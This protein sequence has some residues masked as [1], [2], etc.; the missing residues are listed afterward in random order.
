MARPGPRPWAAVPPPDA[1]RVGREAGQR[2][3][4]R[5]VRCRVEGRAGDVPSQRDR[6]AHL[7]AARHDRAA[8]SSPSTA[9]ATS[10]RCTP[11]SRHPRDR[12]HRRGAGRH[13]RRRRGRGDGLLPRVRPVG[14]DVGDD[15]GRPGAGPARRRAAQRLRARRAGR[16]GRRAVVLL[17]RHQGGCQ[18][19]SSVEPGALQRRPLRLHRP[20]QG[21]PARR[22]GRRPC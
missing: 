4:G 8:S 7:V 6:R 16:R 9:S 17:Q 10:S 21:D 18:A 3:G 19:A 2:R 14:R 13:L 15:A 11:W 22:R 5:P 1:E 20:D 12:R